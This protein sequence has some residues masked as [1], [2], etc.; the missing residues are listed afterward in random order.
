MSEDLIKWLKDN[1]VKD[2]FPV[3]I[4]L[5]SRKVVAHVSKKIDKTRAFATKPQLP[6]PFHNKNISIY[7]D[8]HGLNQND[9]K[10]SLVKEG[11]G[12]L[13]ECINIAFFDTVSMW[14]TVNTLERNKVINP[15]SLKQTI[16]SFKLKQEY[17]Y[18]LVKHNEYENLIG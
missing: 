17:L 2:L 7:C 3:S 12:V 13:C 10:Q 8:D 15:L 5:Y 1:G 16:Q 11:F 9:L 18:N 6:Q 14:S 4:I